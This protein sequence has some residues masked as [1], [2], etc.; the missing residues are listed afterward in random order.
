MSDAA[1]ISPIPT[2][3]DPAKADWLSKLPG[4]DRVPKKTLG[5]D[6]F[7]TLLTTQLSNQDPLE[8]QKDTEFIAQMTT[9]NSA[10][11]MSELV[12]SMKSFM[13]TQDFSGVQNYL[14][15]WVTVKET[16]TAGTSLISGT[17]TRAG[18]DNDGKAI[19]TIGDKDYA[20]KNIVGV[21]LTAPSQ[22]SSGDEG[23][24][25]TGG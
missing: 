9:F 21:R 16:T 1:T 23:T 18:Y 6:D 13:A 24:P 8:P 12:T 5:Q 19:V 4:F 11:Q 17:V 15:K 14:G 10:N 25:S 20:P 7:L 2:A 3:S 22:N